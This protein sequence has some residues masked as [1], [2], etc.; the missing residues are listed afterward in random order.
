[1]KKS[2]YS[3][4]QKKLQKLL[5][6]LRAE[7][8]LSQVMMAKLLEKP[9]SFISK[10]ETGERRLDILEIRHLCHVLHITLSQFVEELEKELQ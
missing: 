8:G 9:Q 6:R 1:M 10:Y 7:S 4:E 5:Q 2:I 3:P